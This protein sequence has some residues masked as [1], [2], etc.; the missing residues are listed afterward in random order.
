MVLL[1]FG[2]SVA[3]F[4]FDICWCWT[5][6]FDAYRQVCFCHLL[7]ILYEVLLW[8]LLLSFAGIG[9][10]FWSPAARFAFVICWYWTWFFKSCCQVCSCHLLVL[11]LLLQGLL[12]SFADVGL[13]FWGP[14]AR[15]AFVICWC[16]TLSGTDE[17]VFLPFCQGRAPTW[18]L[19]WNL[20][21]HFRP[22]IFFCNWLDDWFIGC[23]LFSAVPK[24][25]TLSHLK[26]PESCMSRFAIS[27]YEALFFRQM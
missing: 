5:Y 24:N 21:S 8:D 9:L 11:N 12:W 17:F 10:T 15:F 7:D 22:W 26:C 19:T 23:D 16:W 18:S 27:K 13:T 3:R 20:L 6:F 2:S 25:V 4:A 14:A 1:T